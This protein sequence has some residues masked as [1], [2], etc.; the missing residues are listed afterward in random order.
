MEEVQRTRSISWPLAVS[1]LTEVSY[2][3][4]CELWCYLCSGLPCSCP[5]YKATISRFWDLQIWY[6][7]VVARLWNNVVELVYNS[8]SKKKERWLVIISQCSR[9]CVTYWSYLTHNI[10]NL[11]LT[12]LYKA[13]QYLN[14][15]F[16]IF[17][18]EFLW[19]TS[20]FPNQSL[21]NGCLRWTIVS[22]C[23]L[24]RS[25]SV[26]VP[27]SKQYTRWTPSDPVV[28]ANRSLITG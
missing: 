8:L 12:M 15:Y 10:N 11:Q 7:M 19:D 9:L 27:P 16:A 18:L 13:S 2:S 6:W 28:F 4:V 14:S 21:L 23:V 20:W 17:T 26:S 22:A 24:T 3:F 25:T 1:L 5:L